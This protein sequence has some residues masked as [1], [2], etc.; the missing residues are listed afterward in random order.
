MLVHLSAASRLELG[1]VSEGSRH[2]VEDTEVEQLLLISPCCS[3][4]MT[5]PTKM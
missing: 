2:R 1:L 3:R 4:V 5:S